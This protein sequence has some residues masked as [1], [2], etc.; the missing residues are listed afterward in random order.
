MKRKKEDGPAALFEELPYVFQ[1]DKFIYFTLFPD[2]KVLFFTH[3]IRQAFYLYRFGSAAHSSLLVFS[4]V[5][6][7]KAGKSM[8]ESSLAPS[9]MARSTAQGTWFM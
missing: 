9:E 6:L 4:V 3:K 1:P 8:G 2:S 5:I 7:V